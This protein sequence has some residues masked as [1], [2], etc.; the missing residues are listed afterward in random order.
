MIGLRGVGPDYIWLCPEVSLTQMRALRGLYT[1]PCIPCQSAWTGTESDGVHTESKHLCSIVLRLLR[2]AQTR[3]L[4]SDYG[5]KNRVQAGIEPAMHWL[6]NHV[7][8]ESFR[9][10]ACHEC[11]HELLRLILTSILHL[12]LLT[13]IHTGLTHDMTQTLESSTCTLWV[14]HHGSK[15]HEYP[16]MKWAKI[17]R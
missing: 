5:H 12:Q 17:S 11:T 9:P 2:P 6:H 13:Q 3:T 8:V 14:T 4:S 1:P 16:V 15:S 10:K 7:T